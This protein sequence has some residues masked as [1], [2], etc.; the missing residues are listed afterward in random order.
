MDLHR[1]VLVVCSICT[2]RSVLNGRMNVYQNTLQHTATHCN[3]LQHT[4]LHCNIH[5]NTLQHAATRCNTLQ[6][7]ATH[8]NIWPWLCM[9]W[10]RL[11]GFSNLQVSF[12]KE[13]YKRDYILQKRPIIL[14][15]LLM[16]TSDQVLATKWVQ[17]PLVSTKCFVRKIVLSTTS[18]VRNNKR[19]FM[20]MCVFICVYTCILIP[21]ACK[22]HVY[23][24]CN[25]TSLIGIFICEY[26]CICMCVYTYLCMCICIMIPAA[27]RPRT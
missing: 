10:L 6:H 13:P 19:I 7:T 27:W 1:P 12:A 9:G 3:T 18:F 20:C 5:C 21:S 14:R 8:C 17:H 25:H 11:V 23:T 22:T 2:I 16:D 15:S 24:A 4:A 26:V